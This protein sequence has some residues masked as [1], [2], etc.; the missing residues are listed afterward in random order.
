MGFAATI[1]LGLVAGATIL[2]GL[3]V[4]RLRGLSVEWRGLLTAT[5]C[6][7]LLFLLWDV[8]SAAVAPIHIVLQGI[9]GGTPRALGTSIAYSL[10][11]FGGLGVGLFALMT[12]QRL[13]RPKPAT[14]RPGPGAMAVSELSRATLDPARHM[15]FAIAVG[16]GLHNF[17]EGL[18]IGGSSAAGQTKLAWALV[19]GF[20]LHNGTEGFGVAGPL[21]SAERRPSWRLLLLLG[22][23]AGGP[24]VVGTVVGYEWTN[25]VLSIAFLGVAA[26]SILF[27]VVQMLTMVSRTAKREFVLS[28][29]FVGLLAGFVTDF[30]L[31]AIGA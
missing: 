2:L 27:V 1:L 30:V 3:P 7:V 29:L 6:G 28:G 23:I 14:V 20:A 15:A 12:Y 21:A 11:L 4:A 22:L 19:I 8:L 16:I 17:A 24:T 25:T 10:V 5:S 9:R 13:S 18:A 26:G 31:T